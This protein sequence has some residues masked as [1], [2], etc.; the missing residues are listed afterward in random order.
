MTGFFYA[1]AALLICSY[2]L[3]VVYEK[4]KY[5]LIVVQ[6]DLL[7]RA[8]QVLDWKVI[9]LLAPHRNL[10]LAR[11]ASSWGLGWIDDISD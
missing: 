5:I 6:L 11:V 1:A 2:L 8:N 7:V 9:R 4:N 3:L 10:R